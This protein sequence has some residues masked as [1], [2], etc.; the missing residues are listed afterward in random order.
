MK[1][2]L[3]TVLTLFVSFNALAADTNLGSVMTKG[4]I[5]QQ[6]NNSSQNS[7]I[8]YGGKDISRSI[9]AQTHESNW[10][11]QQ[12]LINPPCRLPS[13]IYLFPLFRVT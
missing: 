10:T 12:I 4:I 2:V 5:K 11:K 1:K 13:C 7:T 3:L 8:V 6:S 9:V